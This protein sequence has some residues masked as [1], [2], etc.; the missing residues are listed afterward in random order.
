MGWEEE[1]NELRRREAVHGL[2]LL[3]IKFND[4][5]QI[6]DFGEKVLEQLR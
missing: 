3:A 1:I 2:A 4:L 5:D 6:R